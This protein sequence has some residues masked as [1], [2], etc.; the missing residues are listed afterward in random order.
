MRGMVKEKRTEGSR[1]RVVVE[2][3]CENQ[4]RIKTMIGEASGLAPT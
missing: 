3:S 1:V 2:F 4:D